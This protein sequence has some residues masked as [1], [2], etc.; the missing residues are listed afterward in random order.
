ML[1]QVFTNDHYRFDPDDPDSRWNA[2]QAGINAHCMIQEG[3]ANDAGCRKGFARIGV[4]L[5]CVPTYRILCML[6]VQERP[7][8]N[9]IDTSPDLWTSVDHDNIGLVGVLE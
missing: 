5:N 4:F 1:H 7:M 2:I 3:R 6:S 9:L 8:A